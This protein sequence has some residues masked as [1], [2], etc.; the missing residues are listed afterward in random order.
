MPL[1]RFIFNLVNLTIT[2]DSP[3]CGFTTLFNL[4]LTTKGGLSRHKFINILLNNMWC[5]PTTRITRG[6]Y[7]YP[8][9]RVGLIKRVESRK[10]RSRES[11][12]GSM[13]LQSALAHRREVS[14]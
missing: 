6:F 13:P 10:R 3:L 8:I 7:T 11:P 1:P 14:F 2:A 9:I 5:R 4:N 12:T